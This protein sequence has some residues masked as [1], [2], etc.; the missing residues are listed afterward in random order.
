MAWMAKS[1][2]ANLPGIRSSKVSGQPG[3]VWEGPAC[4]CTDRV[5]ICNYNQFS[6]P[7]QDT[8]SN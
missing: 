4:D 2:H 5:L 6:P 8:E 3:A 1:R 7:Q